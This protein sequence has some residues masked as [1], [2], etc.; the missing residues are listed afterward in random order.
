MSELFLAIFPSSQ[1][2]SNQTWALTS[3]IAHSSVPQ[4]PGVPGHQAGADCVG[5][6][7]SRRGQ[8]K[9]SRGGVGHRL[10]Q[11]KQLR[12]STHQVL[13]KQKGTCLLGHDW[14]PACGGTE[15]QDWLSSWERGLIW[16]TPLS[17]QHLCCSP[18][19]LTQLPWALGAS[20]R[21][22]C[23]TGRSLRAAPGFL[24][25]WGNHFKPGWSGVSMALTP[26]PPGPDQTTQPS[27]V[28]HFEVWGSGACGRPREPTWR[29]WA[30]GRACL[31][32]LPGSSS[33]PKAREARA[34]GQ[35]SG[36]GGHREAEFKGHFL[37]V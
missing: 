16:G 11:L 10:R 23:P 21:R 37:A 24:R 22:P 18:G 29:E 20:L 33:P 15:R 34:R 12:S 13:E 7:G 35:G 31:T 9:S 30:G 2:N 14:P 5:G 27:R 1:P 19:A 32:R 8:G 17:P 26:R 4:P 6:W 25:S 3:G 36:L 28:N